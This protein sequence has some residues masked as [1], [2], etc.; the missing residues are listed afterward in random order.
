MGKLEW[1][2]AVGRCRCAGQGSCGMGGSLVLGESVCPAYL[3]QPVATTSSKPVVL[4]FL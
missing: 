3:A 1:G 2:A 4:N